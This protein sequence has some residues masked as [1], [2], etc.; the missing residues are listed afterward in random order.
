MHVCQEKV[1]TRQLFSISTEQ[2]KTMSGL[3]DCNIHVATG[4]SEKGDVAVRVVG[5]VIG[6]DSYDMSDLF[7]GK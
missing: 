7:S 2:V 3:V 4:R 6:R 5:V 1:R